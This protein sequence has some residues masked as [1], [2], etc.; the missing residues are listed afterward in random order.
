MTKEKRIDE[1]SE[2]LLENIGKKLNAKR[3][4]DVGI[5]DIELTEEERLAYEYVLIKED[6]KLQVIGAKRYFGEANV[7][8][9]KI[10]E[11]LG[12]SK[13]TYSYQRKELLQNLNKYLTVMGYGYDNAS[14]IDRYNLPNRLTLGKYIK[15]G[16][17]FVY[18]ENSE[19]DYYEIYNGSLGLERYGVI[20]VVEDLELFEM[21]VD[22]EETLDLELEYIEKAVILDNYG[23]GLLLTV[24]ESKYEDYM[25]VGYILNELEVNVV[26]VLGEE[27]AE[28]LLFKDTIIEF[29]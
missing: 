4:D 27:E 24:N 3:L 23:V 2:G 18:E 11:E 17:D 21:L 26:N 29:K 8:A 10:Y 28:E 12:I 19:G 16:N 13:R 9:R 5:L 14:N 6:K 15:S 7:V 22:E 25:D 20:R 1:Y